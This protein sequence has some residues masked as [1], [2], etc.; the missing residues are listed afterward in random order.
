MPK[1]KTTKKA[2]KPD[3]A[4]VFDEAATIPQEAYDALDKQPVK[5]KKAPIEEPKEPSEIIQEIDN[6]T[7]ISGRNTRDNLDERTD[8]VTSCPVEAFAALLSVCKERDWDFKITYSTDNDYC[9]VDIISTVPAECQRLKDT[10]FSHA[11]KIFIQA[12]S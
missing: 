10:T 11:V 2:N 12:L 6:A 9:S 5:K 3:V 4:I 7:K 1:K 8:K